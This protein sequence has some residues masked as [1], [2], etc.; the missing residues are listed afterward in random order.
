MLGGL[1]ARLFE[2]ITPA[3]QREL[4]RRALSSG[5]GGAQL[6]R[7]ELAGDAAVR[8]AAG[9]IVDRALKQPLRLTGSAG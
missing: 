6:R 3:L 1:Y 4:R 7:S 8:G 2:V 5:R 9:L